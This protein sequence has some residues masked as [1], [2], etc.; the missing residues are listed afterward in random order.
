M[1]EE[2]KRPQK[3]QKVEGFWLIIA[4]ICV[5]LWESAVA[6]Q[7]RGKEVGNKKKSPVYHHGSVPG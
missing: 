6:L 7:A 4:A 2:L 1:K 3:H 5:F